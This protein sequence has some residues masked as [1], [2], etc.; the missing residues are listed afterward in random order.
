QG[1][2]DPQNARERE[3]GKHQEKRQASTIKNEAQYRL[4]VGKGKAEIAVRQVPQVQAQ[5]MRERWVQR[6]L[7]PHLLDVSR[8]RREITDQRLYRVTGHNVHD[9][10]ID[11]DDSQNDGD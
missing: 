5:L 7:L 8:R 9:H 6:E 1:Q 2:E 11:D 10:K 3:R 4:T